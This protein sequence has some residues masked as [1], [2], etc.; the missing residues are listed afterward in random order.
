M[1]G[2]AGQYPRAP[3]TE[4]DGLANVPPSVDVPA[5]ITPA[6]GRSTK[7]VPRDSGVART[8]AVDPQELCT[9]T[10][11]GQLCT[12]SDLSAAG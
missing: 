3:A 4:R 12:R 8:L 9:T 6:D 2:G 7:P 11:G 10:A 1:R 5:G